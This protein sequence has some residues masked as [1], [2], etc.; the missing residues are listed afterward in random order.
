MRRPF[1][2][3][4][5]QST[6]SIWSWC[7]LY[8]PVWM[9]PA[10]SMGTSTSVDNAVTQAVQASSFTS[11][12][13]CALGMITTSATAT[14]STAP[15]DT[16]KKMVSARS[17]APSRQPGWSAGATA[18]RTKP[19][20]PL[21]PS[22]TPPSRLTRHQHAR[23]SFSPPS[24]RATGAPNRLLLVR[25]RVGGATQRGADQRVGGRRRYWYDSTNYYVRQ[26]SRRAVVCLLLS[27]G[28]TPRLTRARLPNV[29]PLGY[30]GLQA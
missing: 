11:Q 27:R 30:R 9:A 2:K 18:Q 16:A 24:P 5:A 20:L 8:Q 10:T 22:L 23:M 1:Q 7:A 6:S 26:P 14:T 17:I 15:I 25:A 13:V 28:V 19:S 4:T 29:V 3:K 21:R 12:S